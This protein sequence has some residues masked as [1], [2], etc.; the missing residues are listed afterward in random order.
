[1][2]KI[3]Q[4]CLFWALLGWG[5]L[6]AQQSDLAPPYQDTVK[7]YYAS[8][9]YERIIYYGKQEL[10]NWDRDT[11][12]SGYARVLI[13]ISRAFAALE[14]YSDAAIYNNRAR[15]IYTSVGDSSGIINSNLNL[16]VIHYY[17]GDS[18]RAYT[19]LKALESYLGSKPDSQD[20][21][22]TSYTRA[23]L[24]AEYELGSNRLQSLDSIIP[25]LMAIPDVA[26]NIWLRILETVNE[27][28]FLE[29][30]EQ[31][32]NYIQHSKLRPITRFTAYL[33]LW[34]SIERLK[35]AG[36][37]PWVSDS[38]SRYFQ[39]LESGLSLSMQG[40]F[41][42]LMAG[43]A[44]REGREVEAYSLQLMATDKLLKA[45]SLEGFE[46]L[47]RLE[48]MVEVRNQ[49][50]KTEQLQ[51]ELQ[52]NKNKEKLLLFGLIALLVGAILFYSLYR[53]GRK[54]RDLSERLAFTRGQMISVLSHDL[55]TPLS[56]V[57]GLL[58]LLEQEAISEDEFK[59]LIPELARTTD[60]SMELL[61]NTVA[62]MAVNR[63][64]LDIRKEEISALDLEKH[65]KGFL[66]KIAADS[67]INFQFYSEIESIVCDPFL[68][69]TIL[70]NLCTNAIKFTPDNGKVTVHFG[71]DEDGIFMA[72]EDSGKGMDPKM[73]ELIE[74]GYSITEKGL[75]S[76]T[77]MGMGLIIVQNAI[78]QL[79][80]S[81]EIQST[82]GKGSV[83]TIRMQQGQGL[84]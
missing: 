8:G 72:V 68:I 19:Y 14:A 84:L 29:R 60:L 3:K 57:Q 65:L 73:V 83:F 42:Q 30:F 47:E 15:R 56:Q 51:E 74:S 82:L 80:A 69:K 23:L 6:Q 64:N 20:H 26:L 16:A 35:I 7:K 17:R 27:E 62:W 54:E 44:A 81:L 4:L 38:V 75:R 77:G 45:D 18:A 50:L 53:A 76:E 46:K 55:R 28:G 58:S 67:N 22:M 41:Y 48:A 34:E 43:L 79:N 21:L 9:D 33:I 1:M 61:E 40:R 31:Y 78:E 39:E 11:L 13:A 10:N 52:V 25:K 49:E 63:D 66:A 32:Q 70:R 37:Y 5:G 59:S 24:S 71:Q 12:S 36:N 2:R